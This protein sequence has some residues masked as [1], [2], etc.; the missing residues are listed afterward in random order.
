[1]KPYP[2]KFLDQEKRIYNYRLSRARRTIENVFGILV[3]K[4]RIFKGPLKANPTHVENIIKAAVCLHNYLRLTEGARYLPSGFVDCESNSGDII[5]GDWRKE[6]DISTFIDLPKSKSNRCTEDSTITRDNLC[7]YF[8]S[9]EGAV[10][11]QKDY[12]TSCGHNP[13]GKRIFNNDKSEIL[14]K[15]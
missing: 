2:G 8:N 10:S 1:M 15:K 14:S 6:V 4:F 7:T 11:W 3:A 5:P 12:V 9:I 13:V